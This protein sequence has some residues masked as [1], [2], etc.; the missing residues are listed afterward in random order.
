MAGRV[1]FGAEEEPIL[2]LAH[3]GL[4]TSAATLVTPVVEFM[5]AERTRWAHTTHA[6]CAPAA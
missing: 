5:H 4:D 2:L 1:G 6:G 3:L